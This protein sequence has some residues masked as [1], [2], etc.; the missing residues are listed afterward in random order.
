MVGRVVDKESSKAE[1]DETSILR[2]A[3]K[4]Q[5]LDERVSKLYTKISHYLFPTFFSI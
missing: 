5:L 3:T 4:E 2:V 1:K